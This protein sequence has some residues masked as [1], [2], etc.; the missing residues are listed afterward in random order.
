MTN[1]CVV[2]PRHI[3]GTHSPCSHRDHSNTERVKHGE[4]SASFPARWLMALVRQVASSIRAF[5][6]YIMDHVLP[7]PVVTLHSFLT[8]GTKRLQCGI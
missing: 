3:N 6:A 2:L 7:V 4:W 1:G 8:R 5:I